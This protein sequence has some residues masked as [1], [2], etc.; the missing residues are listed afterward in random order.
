MKEKLS[1]RWK[2]WKI[3]WMNKSIGMDN[4]RCRLQRGSKSKFKTNLLCISTSF[5]GRTHLK[6]G[7]KNPPKP[8]FELRTFLLL[9]ARSTIWAILPIHWTKKSEKVE[10]LAF[11]FG[12][13]MTLE[14]RLLVGFLNWNQH[15]CHMILNC[16]F[17]WLMPIK[18]DMEQLMH[19]WI[20]TL[21]KGSV[22]TYKGMLLK[23]QYIFTI[24]LLN[25]FIVL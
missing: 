7:Q 17:S 8:V 14:T 6:A 22:S 19:K 3:K 18:Y 13:H 5:R 2:E 9:V 12:I 10:K 21:N 23:F 20:N 1:K 15:G 24:L 16:W 11:G 25:L 4:L